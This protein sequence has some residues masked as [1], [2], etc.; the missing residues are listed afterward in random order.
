MAMS[1]ARRTKAGR[2]GTRAA[3]QN[4]TKVHA[5]PPVERVPAGQT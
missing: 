2:K 1:T 3:G 5:R 4:L